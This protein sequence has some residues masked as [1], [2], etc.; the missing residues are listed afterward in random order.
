MQ[1]E[2]PKD[3]KPPTFRETARRNALFYLQL[4]LSQFDLATGVK[5]RTYQR[6]R[7]HTASLGSSVINWNYENPEQSVRDLT[8]GNGEKVME[9]VKEA[10]PYSK[11]PKKL[12]AS[13]F[14]DCL[15]GEKFHMYT[16]VSNA[17]AVPT[18]FQP[19]F[20]D[21]RSW[22]P[23][24]A[25]LSVFPPSGGEVPQVPRISQ[26]VIDDSSANSDLSKEFEHDR[27]LAEYRQKRLTEN[28]PVSG[29]IALGNVFV[30]ASQANVLESDLY[31]VRYSLMSTS[32]VHA[33]DGEALWMQVYDKSDKTTTFMAVG[34]GRNNVWGLDKLN[35]R[36]AGLVFSTMHHTFGALMGAFA[37]SNADVL[38]LTN[39]VTGIAWSQ[40]LQLL[41]DNPALGI[42]R[43]LSSGFDVGSRL[44]AMIRQ[45][46]GMNVVDSPGGDDD[47]VEISVTVNPV[48]DS[49]M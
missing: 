21:I 31:V 35:N 25:L 48:D 1:P 28:V 27:A 10:T 46:A 47:L 18:P 4:S 38:K 16:H 6:D 41:R 2:Q 33:L 42:R 43:G 5:I 11:K 29:P 45:G 34:G 7:F 39:G 24:R 13:G 17:V 9:F 40:S 22:M 30:K 12:G 20:G 36:T 15:S 23:F 14:T 26:P 19:L 37:K 32:D 44:M 8:A 49:D 3:P